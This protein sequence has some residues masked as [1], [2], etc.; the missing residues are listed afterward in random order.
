[1]RAKCFGPAWEIS[2]LLAIK[3]FI[4]SL[5]EMFNCFSRP[6]HMCY[7]RPA[8]MFTT[9]A[10]AII[11]KELYVCV[12]LCVWS[13]VCEAMC[14]ELCVWSCV[15]GAMCVELCVWSYVCG[16]VCVEL[17]VWSYV[18]GAV[19]VELYVCGAVCVELC[20]WSYV[21]AIFL[22]SRADMFRYK[23]H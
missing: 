2:R 11:L 8:H 13:C 20:V 23:C 17:C 19:C 6:A 12:E 16:A 10:C 22:N 3:A 21:C 5:A 14:V 9:S 7:S 18:C 4:I 1:M 15:C